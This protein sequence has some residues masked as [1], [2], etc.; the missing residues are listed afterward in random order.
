[1][2]NV[3]IAAYSDYAQPSCR[4]LVSNSSTLH[5]KSIYHLLQLPNLQLEVSPL[6]HYIT[7]V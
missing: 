3:L 7:P 5:L 6:H 4:P 2:E 1:M